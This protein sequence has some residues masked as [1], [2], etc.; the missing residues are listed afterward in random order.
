MTRGLHS[1]SSGSAP[2]RARRATALV[3]ATL[4]AVGVLAAATPATATLS[5]VGPVSPAGSAAEG[6]PAWYGDSTGLAL[7][8]CLDGLPNC[9][10]AADEFIPV[11]QDGGD[12]EAFYFHAEATVG[13]ITVFNALEAAYAAEGPDQELVFVRNQISARTAN[14]LQPGGVYTVTDPYGTL[15]SCTA[16]ATGNIVNNA[17][18][19]ETVPAAL[20]FNGALAGRIGPFLTWD[21]Y[22]NPAL[23]APPPAGYIGDNATP[24]KVVGSPN[25]FNKVRVTGPG[26]NANG[27]QPCAADWTGPAADCAETDLF[28]VQGKVHPGPS[29]TL[30]PARL[31]FGNV[32]SPVTR[33]LT[34]TSTGS[35]NVTVGT[36]TRSGSADFTIAADRCGGVTVAPGGSCSVDVTYTPRPGT[37]STGSIVITDSTTGS[38]RTAALTGSSLPVAGVSPATHAFGTQKVGTDSASQPITVSNSGVAPLQVSSATLTGAGSGQ[39]K[40]PSNGCTGAVAPGSSCEIAVVFSPLSNGAKTAALSLVTDGGNASVA[41]SGTGTTPVV[42]VAPTSIA[43]GDQPIGT[44]SANRAVTVTNSGSAPVSIGDVSLGGAGAAHFRLG[45]N[46][47]TVG[48]NVSPGTSCVIQVAFSPTSAGLKAGTLNVTA[49]GVV[50]S[51]TLSGNATAPADTQA[52]SAPTGLTA[53][54]VGTSRIDLSWNVSTDNVGVAGYRVFRD[55][56]ATPLSTVTGTSFADTGLA[57]GSTHT[58]RVAAFDAASPP[59][60]SA[61][62]ATAT[63]TTGTVAGVPGAPTIGTPTADN[64]AA[65]VR[66]TAPA[67]TGGAPVTGYSVRTFTGPTLVR[68]TTVPNVTSTSITGLVNGTSYTFDVAAINSAGTGPRSA[69]SSE[70]TPGADSV[71][72]TI[73]SRS[74]A[75]D[76][77]AVPRKRSIKVT[78][79]EAVTGV[80]ESTFTLQNAAGT[81]V[82][83]AVSYDPSS[84]VATF[85]PGGSSADTLA[86]DASYTATLT[87]GIRDTAGNAL[88]TTTW[89]FTTGPRP[90]VTSRTPAGKATGVSR[91][92]NIKVTFSEDV[93]GWSKSTVTLQRLN[94][95]G[96][97][98]GTVSGTLRYSATSGRGVFNPF[99]SST[100]RLARSTRYRMNLS[101]GIEDAAGNPLKA[102]SWTF[103]TRAR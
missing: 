63:A 87:S 1:K 98:V 102:T 29:A 66:W 13:P 27:R 95:A 21:T 76:A 64:A 52:P 81:S 50:S 26:I 33:V 15:R 91:R 86:V 47:C 53:T 28:V 94:A 103:T 93:T 3:A 73:S 84:R 18:R 20:D 100:K 61:L 88:A 14:S 25:G 11:H 43:F 17:C 79:S 34:Y 57:P 41:L 38:P 89:T 40:V 83:G 97:V 19:T 54:A 6:F 16:S 65:T 42:A 30:S 78:F 82:S 92:T 45:A 67:A 12:A 80:S 58:Y 10:V 71:A 70:V 74:P 60:V 101:P 8:P 46:T 56:S 2:S 39:F 68:T 69:R 90:T 96:A 4:L 24:H 72:P 55:G 77:S 23:G 5:R 7:E 48:T 75:A 32:G 62:S 22:G 51:A 99:G 44:A 59:N 85:D 9:L 31:N 37:S 36:V 49:D 35:V